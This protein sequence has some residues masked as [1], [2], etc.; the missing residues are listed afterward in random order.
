MYLHHINQHFEK[1]EMNRM[2]PNTLRSVAAGLLIA[3]G[4]CG[5]VY[6]FGSTEETNSK[7]QEKMS[8]EEMKDVLTT[9]GYVVLTED[10]LNNKIADAEANVSKNILTNQQNQQSEQSETVVYR[11]MIT[12][13]SGMTSI[14]VGNALTSAK[15]IPNRKAFTDAVEAKG[16]VQNLRPGTF[17]VQSDMTLDEVIATIYKTS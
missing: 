1:G 6:F 15:I 14:D 5:A 9:E 4:V 10:E 8:S 2:N 12:V 17:E 13:T 3:T 7:Q 16:L 11:T